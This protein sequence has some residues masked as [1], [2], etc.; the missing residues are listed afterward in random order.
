MWIVWQGAFWPACR[1]K[2][3]AVASFLLTRCRAATATDP[4]CFGLAATAIARL[5]HGRT[6]N[7]VKN[8][9]HATLRRKAEGNTL[10][11]RWARSGSSFRGPGSAGSMRWSATF[12]HA[13]QQP[14]TL[15]AVP[16]GTIF[17]H[18]LCC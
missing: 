14:P 8:H 13:I 5:L 17:L 11:N 4:L 15:F 6:D 10:Q 7:S 18:V 12:T 2:L 9:W 1:L 16:M 3:F